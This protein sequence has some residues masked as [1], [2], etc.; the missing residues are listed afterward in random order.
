MGRVKEDSPAT[1]C[2]ISSPVDATLLR[3]RAR[4]ALE[5]VAGGSTAAHRDRLAEKT[6]WYRFGRHALVRV[7]ELARGGAACGVCLVEIG[8]A[9]CRERVS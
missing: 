6:G 2:S 8:R 4:E 7:R 3:T 5:E 9:S 1:A